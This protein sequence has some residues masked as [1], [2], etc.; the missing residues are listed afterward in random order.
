MERCGWIGVG[1][2]LFCL[3]IGAPGVRAQ[4][5][6][7]H[8]VVWRTPSQDC[9]GSMPLGNGEVGLNAWV[10]PD[11]DLLFYVA[12]TDSWGDNGRLLKLGRVRIELDPAPSTGPGFE[13][14][15]SLADATLVV[16][17]GEGSVGLRLWVDAHH[18]IVCVSVE[19]ERPVAVT[20][21]LEPWRTER[22]ELP[23]IEVSDVLLDRSRP[24]SQHAPT[25]VEPDELLRDQV[26]RIGWFHHNA[27]SNGPALT[28]RIQGLDGL[29]R[30]DPLLHRT[31]GAVVVAEGGRRIDD[32]RLLSPAASSHLFQV[33]AL[34]RHPASPE[35][36]LEAVD[37]VLA[38]AGERSFDERRAAHEEWWEEFYS[39]S[40]ISITSSA[41]S[42]PPAMIPDNRHPVRVGVDQK[43]GN[44]FAGEF[45]R[46]S[47]FDRA[48]DEE[49]IR[50]LSETGRDRALPASDGL[51]FSGAPGAGVLEGSEDWRFPRGLTL[52][53]W[54]RPGELPPGGGRVLDKITPGQDDGFLFDTHPGSSLRLITASGALV[55]PD[56]LPP[57]EWS[58]AAAVV[59]PSRGL[60][61]LYLDGERIAGDQTELL[62]D[63]Q[64]VSR[65]YALQRFVDACAGRGRYPIKFNGSIFTVPHAGTPGDADYRRWG[66]GYWWQNTRLPYLSMCASGDFE[67]VQPLFRMYAGDLMPLFRH[68]T[69]LYFGHGGAFVPE[70]IYFWGEVFSETYGWTPFDERGEDKLQTSGWHKWEWVS[71]LELVW[72]MLD[73]HEYT[74]DEAFLEEQLLPAAHEVL[75]FFDEHYPVGEDGRLV[76]HPSQ[77]LETWWECT[78]PMPEVAGLHA[79]TARL[80]ALPPERTGEARRAHWNALRAKLPEL[81]THTVEGVPMLAPAGE[82]AS[83]R[84]IENPELY[85]VFP[86]RL[87]SFE[88]PNVDLGLAALEHRWDRGHFGW[89]QDDLFMAHLGLAEQARANLVARAR[90]W[91]PGSRFPAFWG[92]NYDWVPDQDHG[93]V[94]MRTLQAMLLQ[95]DGRAI[96]LLPAW[97]KDWNARFRLHAP[98]RT[99]IKCEFRDG[100]IRSLDIDPDSRAKDVVRR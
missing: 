32:A 20:A 55:R 69:R 59:D 75:T 8:D 91:H 29:Q 14:R 71:G 37:G 22:H 31:F 51:L 52:E 97:P 87:V 48:L 79:V 2:G 82:F 80:L 26:G 10:E 24:G 35:E 1:A 28:A 23:S 46:V 13:T 16:S 11:G 38:S 89:R 34:T 56:A 65:A 81:P 83:K 63:A 57:R 84:N 17:Y 4:D 62:D 30:P 19:A 36:W 50:R 43:G 60:R 6:S 42:P 47:L 5:A 92:P 85:A 61:A 98:Y 27:R 3:A 73:W 94:L 90:Q 58:H 64:V 21:V 100:E 45:G 67:M 12:R 7:L 39:R 76:M 77:A 53:A 41:D 15:L 96:H 93:G 86:F 40:W 66:P 68:R 54:I 88:K 74:Q 95:T 70:C 33:C 44:R 18:P 78:D 9:G 72:M 49:A 25:F 99:Q